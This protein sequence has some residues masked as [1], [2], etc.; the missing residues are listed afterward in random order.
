[1]KETADLVL[2]RN[3]SSSSFINE[4]KE[5]VTLSDCFGKVNEN[6]IP[7]TPEHPDRYYVEKKIYYIE[8][9]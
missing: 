5:D 9:F 7:L 1:M 6:P 4:Q 2:M 3:P 8:R